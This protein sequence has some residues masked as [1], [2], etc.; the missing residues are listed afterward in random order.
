MSEQLLS[1]VTVYK[2]GRKRTQ[3]A[4]SVHVV[5]DETIGYSVEVRTRCGI[6]VTGNA[7][8]QLIEGFVTCDLCGGEA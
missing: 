5:G 2:L 4:W 8:A 6:V 7:E 1:P 3:H